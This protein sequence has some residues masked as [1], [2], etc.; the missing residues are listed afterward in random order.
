MTDLVSLLIC[1]L[2]REEL[3]TRCV[4]S[5]LGQTYHNIEI[6]I[7]DQSDIPSILFL[8]NIRIKYIHINEYG[9][10]NARNIGLEF[11]HGKWVA[12]IDDD[13]VYS[14]NY[15][16]EAMRFIEF[17]NEKPTIVSGRGIDP[18]S[19]VYL[20]PSMECSR[21]VKVRWK[22]LFKYCMSAGMVINTEF[23][24]EIKFDIRFGVGAGTPYGSGEES[25]IVIQ[26]MKRKGS[27]Y[28]VPTMKFYHKADLRMSDEKSFAYNCGKG[29]L[30]KKYYMSYNRLAFLCLL[31]DSCFRSTIGTVLY[32]VGV[33]K[34]RKSLFAL[35]GKLW[36]F[37]N[38][39]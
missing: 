37:K 22:S 28:Y 29:A 33:K 30:L 17:Q 9:L 24:K 32:C 16:E 36:G 8:N 11:C 34:Y 38:F 5:L 13:A 25:D 3:L 21:V 26:A 12:L 6:I 15:L 7:V 23:L 20:I 19:L 39:H 1:T 2:N 18:K 35:K 14:D 10:S 31:I 27:V 4:E